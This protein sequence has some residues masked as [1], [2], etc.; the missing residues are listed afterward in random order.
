MPGSH[1]EQDLLHEE[2]LDWL[3]RRDDA[4]PFLL[5]VHSM[6]PHA[7]YQPREPFWKA[8]ASD[9]SPSDR[10]AYENIE[11][12]ERGAVSEDMLHKLRALY[13]GEIASNDER[14]GVLLDAVR[15]RGLYRDSL[16][17]FISDHGE[18]F[19][20]RGR[21]GHGFY[22]NAETQRIPLLV[23]PPGPAGRG[24]RIAGTVSQV[25]ILPTL[26]DWLAVAS[27][28][29]SDGT[30]F[31]ELL[32]GGERLPGA[33]A[34]VYAH[35]QFGNSPLRTSVTQGRWT[36]IHSARSAR[37]AES[38]ELY[39]RVADPSDSTDVS[40][41]HPDVVARL[42]S[43]L[44]RGN[45]QAPAWPIVDDEL[46]PAMIEQLEALGYAQ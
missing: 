32:R 19:G 2:V 34:P 26:L 11:K 7:P 8:L 20:E 29:Q 17:L 3:Q 4:R 45:S 38:L 14:F 37:L 16:I 33:S 18:A 6:E 10:A 30:S 31:A 46:E 22:L 12:I 1:Q 42:L 41:R 9:V 28:S 23:K 35:L 39:D 15:A 5:F 36:L 43:L 24:R 13:D 27:P 25:D 44:E 21:L 40:D